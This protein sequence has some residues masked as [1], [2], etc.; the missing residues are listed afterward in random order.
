MEKILINHRYKILKKIGAGSY[1]LIYKGI[2]TA[3]EDR[4]VAIKLEEIN[5]EIPQVLY[6]AKVYHAL[7]GNTGI[8]KLHWA[9]VEGDYNIMVI[10]N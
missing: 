10:E 3:N 7:Q 6:E 5:C 1:G 2:D 9:G 4:E 8:P